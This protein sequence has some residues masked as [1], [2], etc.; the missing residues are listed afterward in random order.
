[1]ASRLGRRNS[2]AS[3]RTRW[4]CAAAV[5]PGV[6]SMT[7]K[8]ISR[9]ASAGIAREPKLGGG[10]DAAL[11]ALGHRFGRVVGAL[12]RLDLDEDQRCAG[13]APRCRFRRTAFSSA[14]PG[15][16][17][18]WRSE[19]WRRGFPPK[20]RAGTRRRARRR[21]A[22]RRSKRLSAARHR[23]LSRRF[24]LRQ[25]ERALIDVAARQ[26]GRDRDFAH[27]ILERRRASACAQQRIRIVR[28]RLLRRRRRRDDQNEFAARF[29]RRRSL[30]PASRAS[31]RRTSS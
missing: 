27:R 22:V 19:T 1:M 12:A 6:T 26:A 17:S 23:S 21:G 4:R 20:G 25:R 24:S 16:D 2:L 14:A 31:P 28:A 18:P 11:A 29:A 7:S 8:R 30:A 10:D 13:G 9:C 15:C 5:L 3:H